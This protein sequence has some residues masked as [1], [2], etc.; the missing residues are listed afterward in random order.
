VIL[1]VFCAMSLG[2]VALL[3]LAG[4][5]GWRWRRPGQTERRGVAPGVADPSALRNAL[6]W[7]R[8]PE[9]LPRW[10]LRLSIAAML[11]YVLGIAA[12]ES[13]AP[14][15]VAWLAVGLAAG[16]GALQLLAR[17]GRTPLAW[18]SRALLYTA[19]ALAVYLD[20]MSRDAVA[21][22]AVIKIVAL[23]LLAVAVVVRMRLSRE[24]R[25]EL[26]TLDVLLIFIA[27]AIPNLPGLMV[28]PS[29][30]GI[31][32]LKLVV[33]VYAV[34]LCTDQSEKGRLV[35]A[36]GIAGCACVIGFRGLLG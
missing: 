3:I 4:R 28:G 32:I 1:A 24:R 5:W 20:H 18:G 31:S 30:L 7:I 19:A 29:N 16:L 15:D 26:T 34:E 10:A 23:P 21:G 17:H 8:R 13:A 9:N 2:V 27:L 25:F 14:Q 36:V 11:V 22:L 35:L 6:L 12:L 33:L